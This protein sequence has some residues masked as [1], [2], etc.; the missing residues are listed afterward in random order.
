MARRREADARTIGRAQ[1]GRPQATPEAHRHIEGERSLVG[2]LSVPIEQISP[3]PDQ[4]RKEFH[5]QRLEE[6]AAS[7]AT[8]GILQPLV[9]REDG[10]LDDGRTHY[11]IVVGGRRYEAARRAKLTRLPVLV[12]NSD[13]AKLRVLQLIENVQREALNPV[14]EARAYKELMGLVGIDTRALA[15]QIHRSHTYVADRLK[16]LAHDDVAAAVT[17]KILTPS[18]AA[19]VARERDAARRQALIEQAQTEGLQKRDI[20]RARR[21]QRAPASEQQQAGGAPTLREVARQMGATEEQVAD[22]AR[23]RRDEPDLTPAEAVALALHAP[24]PAAP[25]GPGGDAGGDGATT[26]DPWSVAA[27]ANEAP[28]GA[29][30]QQLGLLVAAAGGAAPVLHVLEWAIEHGLSLHALQARI[31]ELTETRTV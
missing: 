16:I 5:E 1:A 24:P 29:E 22:A 28:V 7:I 21:E 8:E 19:E 9:V 26:L 13:G 12:R 11:T 18:A 30:H 2:A 15:E 10:L 27:P 4:P 20:Q 6:L 17:R 14:D 3:D 25:A 31:R 23:A